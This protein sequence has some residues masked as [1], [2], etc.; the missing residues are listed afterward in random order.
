MMKELK[1]LI[2]ECKKHAFDL[3]YT[4]AKEWKEEKEGNVL[5]GYMPIYF[6]REILHAAK[7]MPA[8]RA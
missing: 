5:V 1:E 6:P 8:R 7:A 2:G 3:M 4:R